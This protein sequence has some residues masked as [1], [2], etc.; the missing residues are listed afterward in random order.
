METAAP[1]KPPQSARGTRPRLPLRPV[2]QEIWVAACDLLIHG[3]LRDIPAVLANRFHT[4]ERIIGVVLLV[5]GMRHERVAAA[6]RNGIAES[7][8]AGHE[9]S[10]QFEDD[11][12]EVA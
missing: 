9:A 3:D 1:K 4:S 5:E 11:I 2:R 10:R 7:L 12:A 6:F 8:N